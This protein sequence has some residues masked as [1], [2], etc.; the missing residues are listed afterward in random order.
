VVTELDVNSTPGVA[1]VSVDPSYVRNK[2]EITIPEENASSAEY[3]W[4]N[5]GK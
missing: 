3:F 1:Y 4:L 5:G 2:T